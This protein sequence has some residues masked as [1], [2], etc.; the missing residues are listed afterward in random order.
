MG[1]TKI[2]EEFSIMCGGRNEMAYMQ[3]HC[4]KCGWDGSKH[5]AYND[6]QHSNCRDERAQHRRTC[7]GAQKKEK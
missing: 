6:Y 5:Y 3:N 7:S 4:K 1:T 2:D